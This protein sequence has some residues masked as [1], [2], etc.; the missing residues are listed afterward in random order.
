[1]RKSPANISA[2]QLVNLVGLQMQMVILRNVFLRTVLSFLRDSL[3]D[4]SCSL[5]I[6]QKIDGNLVKSAYRVEMTI[7]YDL[8]IRAQVLI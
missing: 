5:Q 3:L 2:S 7:M 6:F 4:T 8:T 1:M